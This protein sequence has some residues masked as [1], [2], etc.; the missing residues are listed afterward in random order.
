M[1]YCMN[2]YSYNLINDD[3]VIS[4]MDCGSVQPFKIFVSERNYD[5]IN[6]FRY[7]PTYYKCITH[8]K[9]YLK[10]LQNLSKTFI[11]HDIM[12]LIKKEMNYPIGGWKISGECKFVTGIWNLQ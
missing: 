7:N 3:C 4:C 12:T 8:F 6:E 11:N 2:C 10:C 1:D 9:K 5:M